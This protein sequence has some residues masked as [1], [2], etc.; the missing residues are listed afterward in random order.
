MG[1]GPSSSGSKPMMMTLNLG[2]E[3][4]MTKDLMTGN[5]ISD[6]WKCKF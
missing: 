1:S 4:P 2:R 3:G 6:P 5:K